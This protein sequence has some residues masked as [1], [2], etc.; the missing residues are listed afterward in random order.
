MVYYAYFHSAVS[1]GIIFWGNYR[2]S[3]CKRGQLELSQE[4]GVE[5]LADVYLKT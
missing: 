2:F 3:K 4:A 5:T 1:Y